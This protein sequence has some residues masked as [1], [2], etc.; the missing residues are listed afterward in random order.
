MRRRVYPRW[1][2]ENR[3]T[4]HNATSEIAK[5]D[6]IAAHFAALAEKERLL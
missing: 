1:V 2:S 6:A 5:M 3:L 4:Q